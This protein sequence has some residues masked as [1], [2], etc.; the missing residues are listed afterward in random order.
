MVKDVTLGTIGKP[1]ELGVIEEADVIV[2]SGGRG[3]Y[4]AAI[5]TACNGARTIL[6]ERNY[7]WDS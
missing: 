1:L 5:A 3:G 6:V 7:R 4:S 2:V